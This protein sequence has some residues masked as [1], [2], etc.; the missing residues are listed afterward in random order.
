MQLFVGTPNLGSRCIQLSDKLDNAGMEV[1]VKEKALAAYREF[2][3]E[4]WSEDAMFMNYLEGLQLASACADAVALEGELSYEKMD[5][6][7]KLIAA[8]MTV[9]GSA[10]DEYIASMELSR[11]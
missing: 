10:R 11:L 4:K 5:T 8:V 6:L 3:T 2:L 1:E 7:L 9:R